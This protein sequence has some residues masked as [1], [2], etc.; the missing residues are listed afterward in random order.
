MLLKVENNCTGCGVCAQ[1]CD[2]NLIK[3]YD[4][5]IELDVDKCTHCSKCVNSC[6]NGA[7]TKTVI[8]KHFLI[9]FYNKITNIF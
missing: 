1:V 5:Y 3:V 2:L 7:F 4:N 6:P 9:L 8:L